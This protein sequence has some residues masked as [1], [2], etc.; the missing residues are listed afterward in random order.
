MDEVDYKLAEDM[1]S[2]FNDIVKPRP[3]PIPSIPGAANIKI[4]DYF[5][6]SKVS[7]GLLVMNNFSLREEPFILLMFK[8]HADKI[9]EELPDRT[10]SFNKQRMT[11]VS[12][13]L[14]K[15]PK[16]GG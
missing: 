6:F 12:F 2:I 3:D 11:L 4:R 8:I 1:L 14:K 15:E 7:R 16:I 5:F 10:R 9:S 13:M